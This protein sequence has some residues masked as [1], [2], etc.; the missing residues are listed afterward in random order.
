MDCNSE[1]PVGVYYKVKI[2]CEKQYILIHYIEVDEW[3]LIDML[4][5]KKQKKEIKCPG[6]K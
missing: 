3:Y 6:K 1:R 4:L 5:M 2:A